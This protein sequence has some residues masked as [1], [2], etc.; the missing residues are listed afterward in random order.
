VLAIYLG[1]L[2][3]G[4]GV[5]GF[6][7]FGGH[8]ADA[9]GHELAHGDHD[10]TAWAV[11]ASLRFWSFGLLAFGL[12]GLLLTVFGLAAAPVAAT[13]AAV[14]GVLSGYFASSVLRR[15]R[16]RGPTSQIAQRDVV[17]KIGRVLVPSEPSGLGKVRVEIKGG[18]VD[19]VAKS[20]EALAENDVVVVED[21][22]GG[23]VTVSKA[24]R[25]LKP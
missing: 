22:E 9:A 8:D 2:V 18:I 19:Y 17:G 7:A 5:I 4:L 15:M 12:L 23:H 16:A 25:E 21:I 14:A 13:I 20:T 1:A 11:V 24:P 6:Q 3:L 10:A